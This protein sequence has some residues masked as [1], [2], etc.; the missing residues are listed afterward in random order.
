MRPRPSIN[1]QRLIRREPCHTHTTD[2][3]EI[4]NAVVGEGWDLVNGSFVFVEQGRQAATSSWPPSGTSSPRARPSATTFANV[5]REE[6]FI[7]TTL[8]ERDLAKGDARL[9]RARRGSGRS[10]RRARSHDPC[11]G[12]AKIPYVRFVEMTG[13]SAQRLDQ[14]RRGFSSGLDLWA[15]PC[16]C[17]AIG[18]GAHEPSPHGRGTMKRIR[19]THVAALLAALGTVICLSIPVSMPGIASAT[20]GPP[21]AAKCNTVDYSNVGQWERWFKTHCV[22]KIL[23]PTTKGAGRGVGQFHA[24]RRDP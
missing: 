1:E 22:V 4:V 12:R 5:R 18:Q 6:G 7:S 9:H 11:R 17:R 19:N 8:A 20:T 3:S 23:P 2:P 24:P 13:L 14:I 21:S 10:D 15:L 16:D